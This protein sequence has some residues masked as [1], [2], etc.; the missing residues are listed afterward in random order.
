[1]R[2]RKRRS[3][4]EREAVARA[5]ASIMAI[6]IIGIAVIARPHLKPVK[7]DSTGPEATPAVAAESGPV[8]TGHVSGEP[9]ESGTPA[10]DQIAAQVEPEEEPEETEPVSRYAGITLTE[11][12]RYTLACLV[13]HEAR[14]E[15]IDGQIAVVEVVFNRMLSPYFPDTVE[16]V[17]FQKYGRVW[18]FSPAPYLYTAEPLAANYV[19]VDRALE[20]LD[21]IT[22]LDT[23]YFSGAPYN[24][25]ISVVIGGHY[26]C[27][28]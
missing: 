11:E 14:G 19:A 5:A 9:E 13:Y 28:I 6:L 12:E 15:P 3:E 24:D 1:M 25:K 17:V 4:A 7:D 10:P 20:G 23:V 8:E 22:T 21:P 27:E 16:D 18:Q 26:F 2:R